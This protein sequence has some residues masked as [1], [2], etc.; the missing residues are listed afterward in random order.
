MRLFDEIGHKFYPSLS[1]RD[2]GVMK[3]LKVVMLDKS[4][5]NCLDLNLKEVTSIPT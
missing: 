1:E 4:K 5:L 3:P 2:K